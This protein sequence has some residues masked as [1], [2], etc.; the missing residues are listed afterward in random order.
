MRILL[1][2]KVLVPVPAP[3]RDILRDIFWDVLSQNSCRIKNELFTTM[4]KDSKIAAS[5]WCGSTKCGYVFN[6]GIAPFSKSLL[7]EAMND[8]SHYAC[9]FDESYRWRDVHACAILAQ[10][11]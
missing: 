9:C 5:F 8:A 11:C 2:R 3:L 6:F 10:Y 4:F 7:A 1:V